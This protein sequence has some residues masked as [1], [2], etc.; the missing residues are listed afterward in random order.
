[1][2]FTKILS[3]EADD[4]A[5]KFKHWDIHEQ[6]LAVLSPPPLSRRG[7]IIGFHSPKLASTHDLNQAIEASNQKADTIPQDRPDKSGGH[8]AVNKRLLD[9]G[10]NIKQLTAVIGHIASGYSYTCVS[11]EPLYILLFP[12]F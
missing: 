10:A 6:D 12:F 8:E 3:S 2:A 9:R 5:L 7:N 4:F 1:M 11:R